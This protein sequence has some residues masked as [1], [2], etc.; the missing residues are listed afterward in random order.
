MERIILNFSKA[1]AY[2]VVEA[3]HTWANY[4]RMAVDAQISRQVALSQPAPRPSAPKPASPEEKKP[5]VKAKLT[6][7]RVGR[8][9]KNASPVQV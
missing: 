3:L 4:V 9:P 2:A 5:A 6:K 1:E 7:R 8:P